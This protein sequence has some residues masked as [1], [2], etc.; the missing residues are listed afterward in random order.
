MVAKVFELDTV[1]G[2]VELEATRNFLLAC[3]VTYVEGKSVVGKI[4]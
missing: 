3:D 2:F 4:S 1:A